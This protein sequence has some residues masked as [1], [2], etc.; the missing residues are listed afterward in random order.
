MNFSE[1]GVDIYLKSHPERTFLTLSPSSFQ[2][3]FTSFLPRPTDMQPRGLVSIFERPKLL[4]SRPSA[5]TP[6][7]TLRLS[8]LWLSAVCCH[9]QG[10]FPPHVDRSPGWWALFA[11]PALSTIIYTWEHWLNSLEFKSEGYVC[12]AQ[13]HFFSEPSCQ[14]LEQQ[15]TTEWMHAWSELGLSVFIDWI[16]F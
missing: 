6:L 15:I 14:F 3:P 11:L 4:T 9:P 13:Q 2:L 8:Q 5:W 16:V 7:P 10:S 1:W 12:F